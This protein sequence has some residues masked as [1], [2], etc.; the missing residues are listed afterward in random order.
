MPF[1]AAHGVDVHFDV[2]GPPDADQTLIALP[3][4]GVDN[5]C[6]IAVHEPLFARRPAWRRVYPDLPGMGRTAAPDW[7]GS[8]DDVFAVV[9]AFA[10]AAAPGRY[11][12][13]GGPYGGYLASGLAAAEP[14][15]I[16]GLALLVPMVE[17]P[18]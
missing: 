12:L 15:R 14:D 2:F 3:G 18:G 5:R 17:P 1:L 9:R 7:I 8:T 16:S 11:A 13:S 4:M 6:V 10:E